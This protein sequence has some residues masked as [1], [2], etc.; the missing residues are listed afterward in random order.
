MAILDTWQ[1]LQHVLTTLVSETLLFQVLTT[2]FFCHK[3]VTYKP[4][5]S[6]TNRYG[7]ITYLPV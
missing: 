4:L 1:N 7:G 2:G 5:F 6:M 3:A